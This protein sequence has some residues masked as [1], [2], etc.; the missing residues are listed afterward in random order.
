MVSVVD[1]SMATAIRKEDVISTLQVRIILPF[2]IYFPATEFV[3]I[4]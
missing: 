2:S 4:L 3:Q 1:L